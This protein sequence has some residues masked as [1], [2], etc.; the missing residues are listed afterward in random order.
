MNEKHFYNKDFDS[1]NEAVDKVEESIIPIPF[2]DSPLQKDKKYRVLSLFSG[3]GGMDLGFEGNFIANRKSFAEDSPY[4]DQR[5]NDNWIYLKKTQFQ[6]VF[7]NDIL[8]EAE[9]A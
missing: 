8:P 7:A 2:A 9:K 6:T 4:I 1:T 5:I 3:C